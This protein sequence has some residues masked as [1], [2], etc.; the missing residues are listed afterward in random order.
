MKV[1]QIASVV[2]TMSAEIL[3]T[4]EVVAENLADVIDIGKKM[5]DATDIDNFVKKLVDHI[6]KV[7]FVNRVYKGTVPSVLMDSW[8]Y[9]SIVEKISAELPDAKENDSWNLTD[10]Q[11][12]DQDTFYQPKVSAKFFNKKTTFEVPVSF[13]RKQV[14]SAFDNETQVNSFFGMIENAIDRTMTIAQDNLIMRTINNMIGQTLH[15]DFPQADYT[16]NSH[17][18]A[19]NLLKLYNDKFGESLTAE[20]CI[21]DAGF[22]RFASYTMG[23]YSVRIGRVSKLFNIEGNDRFTSPD[24]LHWVML[25]DFASAADSY[26]QSD[27]FHNSFTALPNADLVPYWQGSGTDYSFSSVSNIHVNI[28]D[29]KGGS[30]EVVA[31]G[32][33][34]VMFDRD[35]LGV[36]NFDRRV[37][38]HYNARAEFVNS[39]YKQDAGYFNDL[40]E[41]FVVF[42]VA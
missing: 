3:G 14:V 20:K 37:T 41:N 1:E 13:A 17:T 38:T 27:T 30:A 31:S 21:T 26:L 23:M 29:G 4:S 39:W 24:R 42:F 25:A 6:G 9:G 36:T 22:I 8:E 15:K 35:A 7:V 28:D 12:Y 18:R 5:I 19:V 11:K 32:I 2:N 33:L 40:G 34:G 16:A 10:G